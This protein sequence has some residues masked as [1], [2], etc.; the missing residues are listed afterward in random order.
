MNRSSDRVLLTFS[1][2][3]ASAG[4]WSEASHKFAATL[5]RSS[6]GTGG[7]RDVTVLVG[8]GLGVP[9]SGA[10]DRARRPAGSPSLIRR[11]TAMLAKIGAVLRFL[12]ITRPFP[13][14]HGSDGK[15][16]RAAP[17]AVKSE[18]DVQ[19]PAAS[20]TTQSVEPRFDCAVTLVSQNRQRL[21]EEHKL[22]FALA[23]ALLL[24]AFASASSIPL[25]AL[26]NRNIAHRLCMRHIH[27]SAI[28]GAP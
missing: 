18:A 22:R 13:P 3:R 10:A 6:D 24:R 19:L 21:M 5:I 15:H 25:N 12:V 27:T 20:R 26:D 23:Y 17:T 7:R 14:V 28:Q 8:P 4:D 9:A 16:P 11:S 1:A 2:G